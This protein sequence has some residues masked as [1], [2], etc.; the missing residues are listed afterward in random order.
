MGKRVHAERLTL[1]VD[2]VAEQLG[3]GRNHAYAGVRSGE[4]PAIR[5]GKRWLVPKA[6]LARL[7]EDAAGRSSDQP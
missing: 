4:I 3:V 6:A 2:E 5:V 1:T 7:L